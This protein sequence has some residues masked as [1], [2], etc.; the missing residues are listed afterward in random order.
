MKLAYLFEDEEY[1]NP[2][3][4]WVSPD[5]KA[6]DAGTGHDRL[7]VFLIKKLG[8][9][10]KSAMQPESCTLLTNGWMRLAWWGKDFS[11]SAMEFTYPQRQIVDKVAPRFLDK[12]RPMYVDI[13]DTDCVATDVYSAEPF[14]FKWERVLSRIFYKH[15][16][17]SAA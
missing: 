8:L 3:G 1:S 12:N 14:P 11:I 10:R 15:M 17:P 5:G 2:Y 7:A 13:V 4:Y 16:A 9:E 6:Y